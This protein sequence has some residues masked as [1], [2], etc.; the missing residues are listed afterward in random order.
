MSGGAPTQFE[1]ALPFRDRREAGRL[2]AARLQ[3][4][5]NRS[6]VVVAAIPRGGVPVGAEIAELLNLPLSIFLVRKLGAPGQEELA[7]GSL[8]SGGAKLINRDV[9]NALHIPESAIDSVVFRETQE[10]L[11]RERLYCRGRPRTDYK[12]KT[13]IVVDDGIATGSGM[14]LAVQSLKAQRAGRVVV[15]VPVGPGSAIAELQ[16]IADDVICLATPSHFVAVGQWY[17]DFHQ[18]S[19]LDVCRILDGLLERVPRSQSA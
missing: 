3:P 7:M 6:D 8:T 19:D 15:A 18:V 5:A 2:L 9:T 13:V 10:L 1:T 12:D 11:R 17:Q 14:R 4:Y 16:K